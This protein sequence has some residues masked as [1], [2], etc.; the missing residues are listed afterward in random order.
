MDPCHCTKC[1]AT[2]SVK[3]YT[4]EQ[5]THICAADGNTEWGISTTQHISHGG[6]GT[7]LKNILEEE[8]GFEDNGTCRCD[9]HAHAMDSWGVD[10]CRKRRPVIVKWLEDSYS[11]TGTLQALK[12]TWTI[13]CSRM[14]WRLDLNDILGSIVDE[15]IRR[16][17]SKVPET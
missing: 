9:N 10:G 2:Y 11:K 6:P 13:I 7:E 17:E 4:C 15:A 16:A 8:L 3:G 12:A 1:G 5:T 14:L